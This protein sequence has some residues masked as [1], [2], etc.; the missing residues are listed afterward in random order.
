MG[1]PGTM[2]TDYELQKPGPRS[3]L[4][5]LDAPMPLR[6]WLIPPAARSF[7]YWARYRLGLLLVAPNLTWMR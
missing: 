2:S 3:M 6:E 1:V 4:P 5:R 7:K